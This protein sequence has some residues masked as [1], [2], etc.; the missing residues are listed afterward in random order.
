MPPLDPINLPIVTINPTFPA[1]IGDKT[2]QPS[3]HMKIQPELDDKDR[4]LV[5]L[6]AIEGAVG[7]RKAR[8]GVFRCACPPLGI[9]PTPPQRITAFDI[10]PDSTVPCH[11]FRPPGKVQVPPDDLGF[12]HRRRG[13]SAEDE[14]MMVLSPVIMA[15]NAEEMDRHAAARSLNVHSGFPALA[16]ATSPISALGA[17][18]N[19]SGRLGQTTSDPVLEL[20]P[21][22]SSSLPV[23]STSSLAPSL[24]PPETPALDTSATHRH[25]AP[26]SSASASAFESSKDEVEPTL[27]LR[28]PCKLPPEIAAVCDAYIAGTPIT[29]ITTRA[30]LAHHWG[31]RIRVPEE[32][33]Y[34][35]L[36]FFKVTSVQERR[37]VLPHITAGLESD[38]VAGQ[39]EWRFMCS[40]IPSG[41]EAG[42]HPAASS[43]CALRPW[44]APT[45]PSPLTTSAPSSSTAPTLHPADASRAHGHDG[46]EEDTITT[47]RYLVRRKQHPNCALRAFPLHLRFYSPLPLALLAPPGNGEVDGD[48]PSGWLC[49]D[50]D[51]AGRGKL[52]FQSLMRHRRCE[53]SF[54]KERKWARAKANGKRKQKQRAPSDDNHGE[55][56]VEGEGYAVSLARLRDPQQ[57]APMS[58]PDNAYPAEV[59]DGTGAVWGDGMQTFTYTWEVQQ[60]GQGQGKG[61]EKEK[62]DENGK[63]RMIHVFTGNAG[64]LQVEAGVLLREVQMQVPLRRLM[65][66]T[67]PYFSYVVG[68]EPAAAKRGAAGRVGE[69]VPVAW[70]DVPKCMMRARD[71]MLARAQVYAE[72]EFTINQLTILGWVTP[73]TRK[74]A[75]ASECKTNAVL[76]MVLGCEAVI[77][78]VP[79]AGFRDSESGVGMGVVSALEKAGQLLSFVGDG[80]VVMGDDTSGDGPLIQGIDEPVEGIGDL[81]PLAMDVEPLA[82]DAEPLAMD[83]GPPTIAPVQDKRARKVP[84]KDKRSITV[85]LVHGDVLVLSGD[86]FAF[87]SRLPPSVCPP[88]SQL[89]PSHDRTLLSPRRYDQSTACYLENSTPTFTPRHLPSDDLSPPGPSALPACPCG[90]STST[91]RP[92]PSSPF[93]TPLS[94]VISEPSMRVAHDNSANET[95]PSSNAFS[96]FGITLRKRLDSMDG[97]H[98]T[99]SATGGATPPNGSPSSWWG[100]SAEEVVHRPWWDPP[101]RK[102]TVPEE[103]TNGWMHTREANTSHIYLYASRGSYGWFREISSQWPGQAMTLKVN[104]I[105]HIEKS[106][107]QDVLGFESETF[108][109]VLAL[110]GVIQCTEHD[111][112]SYQE[113]IAHLPLASHP[114]PKKVLVIGGGDGGVVREVLKHAT[115]E[116][117]VLCDI[118][119]AVPRV[120]KQYLPHMSALF[121]DP[122]VTVFIGDGFKFLAANVATYDAIITDSSD[123]VGPAAALFEKPYF[124]LKHDAL[125]PGGHISTQGECL[126]LHLPL[127]S[128]LRNMSRELFPVAEYAYTT[129]PTYPSG[130]ISFV[131][132][133]KQAGR[134][135]RTPLREVPDTKYYNKQLHHWQAKQEGLVVG[136]RLRCAPMRG[137]HSCRTLESAKGLAEGLPSTIAVSLNVLDTPALEAA[138]AAHDLVISLIPYTFHAAVIAAAIKGKT[139]VVTTSYVSPAMRALDAATK[140]AGIVVLNEIGL[141]PGI[142]HLYAVKTIDEVHAKGG[143]IKKFLSYCSGLPAPE[144]ANNPLRY[145]FSWS[146]HGVLLALLNA[147]SFRDS[148]K[149]VSVSG[150]ELMAHAA[151]YYISPAF[152]FVAYPNRDSTP[153]S[154]WYNIPRPKLLCAAR[155]GFPEFISAL[156]KLGWLDQNEKEWLVNNL[157]WAQVMQKAVGA[158]DAE[159][160]TLVVRVKELCAFPNE[161]EATRIISGLRWIGLFAQTEKVVPRAR[162]L[163][164]TLCARLETLMKYEEGERD[165]VMLRHKFAVQWSD[166]TE[167]TLTSTLEAYGSPQGHS[168]M[169]LTIGLPCGIASQ[170]VLDGVLNTPGVQAPYT[171]EICDPIRDILEREGLGLVEKVL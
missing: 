22:P 82:M 162:N 18:R 165:L 105:L 141:D 96:V 46:E 101:R 164:D 79:K 42:A 21:K 80:D 128:E 73:G 8:D 125:A 24:P 77:T 69:P 148:S 34:V 135:L 91:M 68:M 136:Q 93:A 5:H 95:S 50:T 26:S 83:A 43:A 27:D 132:C 137:V 168:A 158:A 6:K 74:G 142:D 145:K 45:A 2:A 161:S 33:R 63:G 152:A 120:A 19:G 60:E 171:K 66:S 53:S 157:S 87:L 160:S 9:H 65:C 47:Q 39:V 122:R 146:S 129:I 54:C 94:R 23:P 1:A 144:C 97:Q 71:V 78:F 13:S 25:P 126:W 32:C 166:G 64:T 155:W 29:I 116:E 58:H 143:K 11:A 17:G 124:Q 98:G 118:D 133:S 15:G 167:Q 103:Q 119:E 115:V 140:E 150:S 51:T 89:H 31:G 7:F 70:A 153:F 37:L 107:Y 109:N 114:N 127:I 72:R 3:V 139:H 62:K 100:S 81:D 49:S 121:S 113:M 131:L 170:L 52:N 92:P 110:D 59:V 75:S 4:N 12:G 14:D 86:I 76:M 151:P 56:T 30:Y 85:T 138:V 102:N 106:L 44:W 104:K 35:F 67:N 134:D 156:V 88:K 123:P 149:T 55:G 154:E 57:A 130:Q 169:A 163:L 41:E 147:A 84:A 112:F 28:I 99:V 10:S 111:K 20:V 36:G 48:L 108:G 40:W 38:H 16:P 61:K 117:V 90:H 159:E